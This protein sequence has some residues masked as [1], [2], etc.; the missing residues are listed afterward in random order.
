MMGLSTHRPPVTEPMTAPATPPPRD[1]RTTE[2]A[3]PPPWL[4]PGGE[5]APGYRLL[6]RLGA[7]GLGEVWE[8]LGPG[9]G[10]VAVKLVRL[11]QPGR[12]EQ[13]ALELVR[14]ARHPH[15]LA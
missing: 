15:L 1:D 9:G 8:A 13:R 4:T 5:P 2:P 10:R 12:L 14:N 11:P 7:G 3:A 6:R